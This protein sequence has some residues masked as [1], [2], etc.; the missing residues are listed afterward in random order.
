MCCHRPIRTPIPLAQ[1]LMKNPYGVLSERGAM[2]RSRMGGQNRDHE[3]GSPSS[4][5]L[6]PEPRLN[7]DPCTPCPMWG[8]G[9]TFWFSFSTIQKHRSPQISF[10]STQR[11][12]NH[13]L[14][15]HCK[16]ASFPTLEMKHFNIQYYTRKQRG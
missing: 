7:H 8:Q 16:S 12:N 1:Q 10:G 9:G 5:S 6:G 14:I 11:R 15:M 2:C 4:D 3:A 13:L